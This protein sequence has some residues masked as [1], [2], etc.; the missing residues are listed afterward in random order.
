M[1]LA[2]N[3]WR[4]GDSETICQRPRPGSTLELH[5]EVF[6]D[7]PRHPQVTRPWKTGPAKKDMQRVPPTTE[8]RRERSKGVPS[9]KRR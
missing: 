2:A 7:K 3:C 6:M 5:E 8:P 1:T 4:I 9:F